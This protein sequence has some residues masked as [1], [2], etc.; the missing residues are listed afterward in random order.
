VI[1]IALFLIG[2]IAGCSPLLSEVIGF[3]T[4]GPAPLG[5]ASAPPVESPMMGASGTD[6]TFSGPATGTTPTLT[7]SVTPTEYMEQDSTWPGDQVT[8]VPTSVPSATVKTPILADTERTPHATDT[9]EKVSLSH[10]HITPVTIRLTALDDDFSPSSITV[11]A[12][13]EVTIIFDNQDEG[14]MHSVVVYADKSTPPIFTGTVVKGVS[15]TTDTFTAPSVPGT[16]V[17]GC[18]IPSPHKKGT[19]IVT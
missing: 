8:T 2:A 4:G 9:P 13:A 5:N 19:F 16:Y 10:S 11:P 17:L 15:T 6:G 14:E 7:P 18:G 3:P 1:L 12:G